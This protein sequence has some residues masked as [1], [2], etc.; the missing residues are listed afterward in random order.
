MKHS[1]ARWLFVG[2]LGAFALSLGLNFAGCT[3]SKVRKVS[4]VDGEYYSEDEYLLLNSGDQEK[5]CTELEGELTVA[6]REFDANSQAILE[7]K[8]EIA[9][10]RDQIVP[11]EREVIRLDS[12]IRTLRDQIEVVKALPALWTVKPEESLSLIASFDNVYNDIDKWYRIYEANLDKIDDPYYIF[13]DTVL[14][15]PRDWPVE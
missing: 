12:E 1:T 15:I 9:S 3:G 4:V 7:A 11:M 10:I 2:V 5:Y 8:N 14:V 6:Q 13:P